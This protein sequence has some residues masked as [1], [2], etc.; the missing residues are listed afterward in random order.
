MDNFSGDSELSNLSPT[1]INLDNNSVNENSSGAHIANITGIDPDGD[2]V[3]L[4]FSIVEGLGDHD[5]FMIIN[6]M[7]HLKLTF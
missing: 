5:M 1:T 2:N 4:I 7:L 3:D 6:N